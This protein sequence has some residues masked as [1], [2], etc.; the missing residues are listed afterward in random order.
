MALRALIMSSLV[1]LWKT[2]PSL[3]PAFRQVLM[4]SVIRSRLISRGFSQKACTPAWAAAMMLSPWR[5]EG[6]QTETI[7]VLS[8]SLVTMLLKLGQCAAEA[9][10]RLRPALLVPVRRV[11]GRLDT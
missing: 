4:V 9:L 7:S 1:R 5:P 10:D 8:N 6:V 11:P 2:Q 3:T